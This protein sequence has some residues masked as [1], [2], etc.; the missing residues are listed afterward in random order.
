MRRIRDF[1]SGCDLDILFC[2][3]FRDITRLAGAGV[4]SRF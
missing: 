3:S 1:G 2:G 4:V